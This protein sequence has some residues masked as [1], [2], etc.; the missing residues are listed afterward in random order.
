M[1]TSPRKKGAQPGN[2]NALKHGFYASTFTS[3]ENEDLE[4]VIA[5]N[6]DDEITMLRVALRRTFEVVASSA[7]ADAACFAL[8]ALGQASIR[9]AGLLKTQRML[10]GSG[11]VDVAAALNQALGEVVKEFGCAK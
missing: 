7:D 3:S 8:S 1:T 11:S 5:Q 2:K 10:Q 6:L 9:L 4:A